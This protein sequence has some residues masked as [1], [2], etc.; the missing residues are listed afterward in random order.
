MSDRT[1]LAQLATCTTLAYN[2]FVAP[3]A[4]EILWVNS[5]SP[6]ARGRSKTENTKLYRQLESEI[7]RV[8]NYVKS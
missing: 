2:G 5:R 7:D 4:E 3:P 8:A 1:T 6:R